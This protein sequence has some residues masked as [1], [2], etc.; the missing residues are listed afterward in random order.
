MAASSLHHAGVDR[1]GQQVIQRTAIV[2]FHTVVGAA[3]RALLCEVARFE[4]AERTNSA[5]EAGL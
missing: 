2:R 4:A 1:H 5:S 3:H